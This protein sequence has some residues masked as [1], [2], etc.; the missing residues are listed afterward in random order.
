MA[1]LTKAIIRKRVYLS[2]TGGVYIVH[3]GGLAGMP[4]EIHVT[5]TQGGHALVRAIRALCGA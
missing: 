3:T 5:S 1:T 4:E 2:G